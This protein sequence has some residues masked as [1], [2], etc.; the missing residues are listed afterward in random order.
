MTDADDRDDN[1]EAEEERRRVITNVMNVM[2]MLKKT[3]MNG[4]GKWR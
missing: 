3:V 2:L 1:G 4:D